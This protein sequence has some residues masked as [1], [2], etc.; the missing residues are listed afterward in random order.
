[1]EG[2]GVKSATDHLMPRD[3]D[4]SDC[5]RRYFD[6]IGAIKTTADQPDAKYARRIIVIISWPLDHF[7]S[8]RRARFAFLRCHSHNGES[9]KPQ[10][11]D[12][13]L[14]HAAADDR[15]F[16]LTRARHCRRR[17]SRSGRYK[18]SR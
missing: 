4:E 11:G 2:A 12:I 13:R 17:D 10:H 9:L 6:A 7:S 16:L 3:G 15:A 5:Q 1:M 8:R 18:S 14:F